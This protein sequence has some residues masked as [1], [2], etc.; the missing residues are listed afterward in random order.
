MKLEKVNC[1]YNTYNNIITLQVCT[2]NKN[3]LTQMLLLLCLATGEV[4]LKA[5]IK[6]LAMT[7]LVKICAPRSQLYLRLQTK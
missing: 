3:A 2:H 1:R 6:L 7:G 5:I 4:C